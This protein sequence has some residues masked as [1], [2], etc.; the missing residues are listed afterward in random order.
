VQGSAGVPIDLPI[1]HGPATGY[2]W[3]FELPEGVE[4]YADSE[5]AAPPSRRPGSSPGTHI[6]LKAVPGDHVVTARLIRP[7]NPDQPIRTARIHLRVS[8]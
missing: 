7:W 3:E 2:Q 8:A 1:S 5:P 4:R 6:R